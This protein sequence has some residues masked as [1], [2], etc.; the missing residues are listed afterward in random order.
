MPKTVDISGK[1]FDLRSI[2]AA[3]HALADRAWPDQIPEDASRMLIDVQIAACKALGLPEDLD[4]TDGSI[5]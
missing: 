2:M 5:D 4:L 1:M 3:A